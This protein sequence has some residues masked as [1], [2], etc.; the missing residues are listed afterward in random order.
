MMQRKIRRYLQ[1]YRAEQGS[2][3]ANA[4]NS[5]PLADVRVVIEMAQ[6]MPPY[7]PPVLFVHQWM[8]DRFRVYETHTAASTVA[9][10]RVDLR[11]GVLYVEETVATSA[12][13]ATIRV[14]RDGQ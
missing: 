3:W 7:R 11:D 9:Q 6:A 5:S 12:A 4:H 10:K 2:D 1:W 8:V 14:G 13:N